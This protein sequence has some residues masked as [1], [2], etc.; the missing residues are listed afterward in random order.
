MTPTCWPSPTE[1]PS[2]TSKEISLPATSDETVI[3]V[4]S[5][6]P[7]ASK[8]PFRLHAT[9]RID[10]AMHNNI[11]FI[12]LQ[13]VLIHIWL[14]AIRFPLNILKLPHYFQLLVSQASPKNISLHCEAWILRLPLL[15]S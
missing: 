15:S 9:A 4:A 2:S 12:D 11:F 7:E 3:S 6:E 14:S 8:V 13:Y 1:S 10:T 5:K